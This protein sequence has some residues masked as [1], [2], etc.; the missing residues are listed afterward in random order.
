MKI[1]KSSRRPQKG[2]FAVYKPS[3]ITS[4]DVV[5]RVRRFYPGCKVGHAGTL[6]PLAEGVLVLAVGRENT[7]RISLWTNKEKEYL[8]EIVVGLTSVTDDAEGLRTCLPE[9]DF[10]RRKFAPSAERLRETVDAYR[11]E[12]VQVPPIYSAIKVGGRPAYR[13]AR[14]GGQVALRPRKVRIFQ[15]EILSWDFPLLRLRIVCGPGVYIRALARDIGRDLGIGAYLRKL[16]RTRVGEY[17]PED[18]LDL[19][20]TFPLAPRRV[21]RKRKDRRSAAGK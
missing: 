6:D 16:T 20:T 9:G 3:G 15:I 17:A 11:G 4:H 10:F 19:E 2:I 14:R 12:I 13:L 8:A 1:E 21:V 5:A 18:C 7:K